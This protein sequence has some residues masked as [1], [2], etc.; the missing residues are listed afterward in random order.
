MSIPF[1]VFQFSR[2][3]LMEIEPVN[4]YEFLRQ[5]L[6]DSDVSSAAD[7]ERLLEVLVVR[8]PSAPQSNSQL[9]LEP[10]LRRMCFETRTATGAGAGAGAAVA[11]RTAADSVWR[12]P[13]ADARVPLDVPL[14]EGIRAFLGTRRTFHYLAAHASHHSGLA[15]V[16]D[17]VWVR[18]KDLLFRED[19]LSALL[20]LIDLHSA[21]IIRGDSQREI[22]KRYNSY[23]FPTRSSCSSRPSTCSCHSPTCPSNSAAALSTHRSSTKSA[24]LSTTGDSEPEES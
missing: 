16:S 20:V 4:L 11:L 15:G 10:T 17:A 22:G 24:E 21:R 9:L 12:L 14:L 2:I 6:R 7:L 3:A 8:P 1:C 19:F 13:C 5:K 18:L 23:V